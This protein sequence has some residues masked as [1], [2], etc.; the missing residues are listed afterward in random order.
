[1]SPAANHR[2]PIRTPVI[3]SDR[4]A[5]KIVIQN[6]DMLAAYYRCLPAERQRQFWQLRGSAADK[7]LFLM[8]FGAH[9]NGIPLNLVQ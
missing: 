5:L 1:M 6:P 7:L 4:T 3:L 2:T 8:R 9:Q